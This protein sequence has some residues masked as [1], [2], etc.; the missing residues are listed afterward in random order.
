MCRRCRLQCR[1]VKFDFQC[2]RF[3]H[4]YWQ[5]TP[6]PSPDLI[7]FFNPG[8]HRSTG[9]GSLDTWPKTIAAAT[10]AGCPLVVTAYT[11]YECPLDLARL[12]KESKRTLELVQ[13]PEPNPFAS[14]RPERNFISEQIAPMIFKN[15]YYFVVKMCRTCRLKCRVVK[16]DFQCRR[17][18]HE[19]C[20]DAS[21]YS[22]P[23][24]I[25]FFNPIMHSPYGYAGHDTWP[26]T[27]L[28]AATANCPIVV[29]AYTELDCPLDLIRL[30][31]EARR[32][33]RIVQQPRLN[34]YGSCRPDR[35]FISD[36]VTPLIFK[37]YHY[38]VVQ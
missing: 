4:D 35:N 15:F 13:P 3:Y 14:Q 20:R 5:D 29:T 12:R 21:C 6:S 32:P 9:F 17:F 25:C 8:L 22:R 10:G 36:E 33:L 34:P 19:Y 2:R 28:A 11:E 24:L 38:F 18:Y 26:D 37:N 23:D 7:C 31:K 30:Q 16:F 27:L 1:V